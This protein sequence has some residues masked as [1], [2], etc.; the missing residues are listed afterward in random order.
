MYMEDRTVQSMGFF[1]LAFVFWDI[2]F[3][4]VFLWFSA[5]KIAS[6]SLAKKRLFAEISDMHQ[7]FLL[8]LTFWSKIWKKQSIIFFNKPLKLINLQKQKFFIE[9][10][11]SIVAQPSLINW[12]FQN[13][14]LWTSSRARLMINVSVCQKKILFLESLMMTLKETKIFL[15]NIFL[16]WKKSD[17]NFVYFD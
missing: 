13:P 10:K 1:I 14:C 12:A 9:N 7:L 4:F 2:L 17:L 16:L 3:E 8:F 11:S 15:A 6:T 5:W